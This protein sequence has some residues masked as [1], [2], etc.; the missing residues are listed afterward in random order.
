MQGPQ[1]GWVQHCKEDSSCVH[2]AHWAL[3]MDLWAQGGCRRQRC[4]VLGEA[5]ELRAGRVMEKPSHECE[6]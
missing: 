2:M 1:M 5:S 6:P 4:E 3:D